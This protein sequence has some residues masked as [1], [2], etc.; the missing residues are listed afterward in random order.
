MC[1]DLIVVKSVLPKHLN[2]ADPDIF[3]YVQHPF[4][5]LIRVDI[6]HELVT[7]QKTKVLSNGIVL[8]TT[9]FGWTPSG[10][11]NSKFSKMV[12]ILVSGFEDN[13]SIV[14]SRYN[15]DVCDLTDLMKF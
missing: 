13:E 15:Y 11:L 6:Y 7:I 3:C 12:S 5:L 14:T 1:P 10:S 4:D 8:I 2:Y 9:F